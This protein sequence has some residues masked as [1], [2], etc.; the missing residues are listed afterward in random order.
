MQYQTM[1]LKP[2]EML[3]HLRPTQLGHY[4]QRRLLLM[5]LSTDISWNHYPEV[6]IRLCY[7]K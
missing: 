2:T 6:K 5:E 7:F 4:L 3:Y 1:L